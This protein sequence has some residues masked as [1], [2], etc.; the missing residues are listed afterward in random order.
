M[1]FPEL[2]ALSAAGNLVLGVAYLVAKAKLHR[3]YFI[4]VEVAEGRAEVNRHG[5]QGIS[6]KSKIVSKA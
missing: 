3:A 5:H 1:G 2:L 4:L 6:I